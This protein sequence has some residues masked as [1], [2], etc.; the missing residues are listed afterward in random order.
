MENKAVEKAIFQTTERWLYSFS[1]WKAEI[2]AIETNLED[3]SG[4]ITTTYGGI[5]GGHAE[6]VED[7]LFGTAT[8]FVR[9]EERLWDLRSKVKVLGT[10][11]DALPYD[12]RNLAIMKYLEQRPTKVICEK[13]FI[14]ER[15]VS[16]RRV[17]AVRMIIRPLLRFQ[18]FVDDV[19]QK[20][21]NINCKK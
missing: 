3:H 9:D 4:K 13:M 20:L 8:G 17:K 11:I 6:G 15:A 21:K 10:A 14:D 7:G 18:M 2:V 5:G 19:N 1:G 12:E 16:Y